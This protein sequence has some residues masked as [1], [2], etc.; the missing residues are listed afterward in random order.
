MDKTTIHASISSIVSDEASPDSSDIKVRHVQDD[1]KMK[2]ILANRRSARESYQRRKKL[3]SNLETSISEM[4]KENGKLVDENL[5]LRQQKAELQR[6]LEQRLGISLCGPSVV[7]SMSL[8]ELAVEQLSK[9]HLHLQN[10]SQPQEQ[11]QLLLSEDKNQ[12]PQFRQE[13]QQVNQ[14]FGDVD[15]ALMDLI[16]R[17]KNYN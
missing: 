16:M 10:Y 2:R 12:F 7:K 14:Q 5:Q 17:G 13:Q 9:H 11:N 4:R 6:L 1:K 3:F 8:S 15:Q